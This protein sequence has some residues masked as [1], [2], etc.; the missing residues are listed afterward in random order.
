MYGMTI[1]EA[2]TQ[3]NTVNAAIQQLIEGKAIL[4]LRVGSGNFQ[5]LYK[6]SDITMDS[7][8]ALRASL[9]QQINDLQ[10]NLAP[11]FR[12]NANIPLVV[13]K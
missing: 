9:L 1:E 2:Q 6:Y 7:L 3:L 13:R 4:E 5:R 12:N 10:P 11:V 8:L